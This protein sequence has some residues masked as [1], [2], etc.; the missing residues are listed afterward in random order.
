MK[1]KLRMVADE[2]NHAHFDG[3]S[4]IGAKEYPPSKL[5]PPKL[6]QLKHL[7]KNQVN[8]TIEKLN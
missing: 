8:L 2:F 5:E 6:T 4:K 3:M 1:K 7:R